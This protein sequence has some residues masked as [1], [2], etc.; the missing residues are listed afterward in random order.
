MRCRDIMKREV[1][2][3][4]PTEQ[5]YRAAEKMAAERIG[6]LPVLDAMKRVVGV[7]TDRDLALRVVARRLPPSTPVEEVMS[8]DLTWVKALDPIR[9]AEELMAATKRS[10]I[11]VVDDF[12][13]CVGIISLSDIAHAVP[14]DESGQLLESVTGREVAHA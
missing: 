11:A 5:V 1:W 6:F 7:I 8:R 3:V 10:R 13:E 14:H 9:K 12:G 4:R 2:S